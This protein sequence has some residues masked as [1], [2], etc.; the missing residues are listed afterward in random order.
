MSSRAYSDSIIQQVTVCCLKVKSN[1][2]LTCCNISFT[3]LSNVNILLV[4][5][6]AG[7]SIAPNLYI[8][9]AAIALS[10]QSQYGST[11]I[12]LRHAQTGS[13]LRWRSEE[14]IELAKVWRVV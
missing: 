2:L 12:Y 14:F 7:E 6:V 3:H 11:L 4:H 13:V 8:E 10:L 9:L 1:H 5:W